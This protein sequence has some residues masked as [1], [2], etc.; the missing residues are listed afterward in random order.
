MPSA[1]FREF[2]D[3]SFFAFVAG[4][5]QGD[6]WRDG[7]VWEKA[8]PLLDVSITRKHSREQVRQAVGMPAKQSIVRRLNFCE[9]TGGRGRLARQGGVGRCPGRPRYSG[10]SRRPMLWRCRPVTK[11]RSDGAQPGL[12]A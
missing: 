1:C 8:N 12:P 3:D 11:T 6:D 2:E 5:D 10:L 4:L 9:W 7:A